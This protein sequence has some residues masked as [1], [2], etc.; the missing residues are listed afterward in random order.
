MKRTRRN[1]AKYDRYAKIM[2]GNKFNEE[3]F[4]PFIKKF[5]MGYDKKINVSPMNEM[6]DPCALIEIGRGDDYYLGYD[7]ES[8]SYFTMVEDYRPSMSYYEPDDSEFIDL[9]IGRKSIS[10]ACFD[11]LTHHLKIKHEN[12][13]ESL[14]NRY[15]EMIEE[16][17]P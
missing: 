6:D 4:I 1:P 15:E 2:I 17:N 9:T 14:Y 8:R 7:S 5:M 12:E 16:E 11:I 13:L 3:T 10:E